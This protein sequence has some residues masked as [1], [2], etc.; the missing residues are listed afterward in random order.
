V[1]TNTLISLLFSGGTALAG[2]ILVFLGG[3]INAYE[4][5][6]RV[7]KTAVRSKYLARA[8]LGL[9]GFLFAILSALSA[10]SL[11]WV[12]VPSLILVSVISILI[13]FLLVILLAF[14]AIKEV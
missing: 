7:Q 14:L 5:F 3:T 2:L 12:S 1:D 11:V 10:L 13:S 9:A 6:D 4:T 8:R